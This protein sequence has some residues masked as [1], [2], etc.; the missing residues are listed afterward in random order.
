M[1]VIFGLPHFSDRF[2]H[3]ICQIP[4]YGFKDINLFYIF[5]NYSLLFTYYIVWN[6]ILPSIHITL[7]LYGCIYY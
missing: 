1:D 4:I 6:S 5:I 2:R 7:C 3:I